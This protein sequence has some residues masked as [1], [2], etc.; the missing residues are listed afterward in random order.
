[1][2]TITDGPSV[3]FEV[4]ERVTYNI[5]HIY[6]ETTKTALVIGASRGIGAAVCARL[7]AAGYSV[8]GT[9]R[10]SGVPEGV[11]AIEA[12]MRD[13]DSLRQAVDTT[14]DA[15]GRLDTLV[16]AAGITRDRLLLRMTAEDIRD[17]LEVNTLGPMLACKAA[18][19]PMLRQRSGS[20]VLLS[21]M[22]VKYGV[23]GQT[24]Y[25]A[26]KGAIEA[27]TRSLAREYAE[28]GI[29]VNA[30]A[31]GATDTDMMAAVPQAE[32]QAMIDGIPMRRLA[33]ADEIASVVVQ[34]AEATY[35]N[36][37]VFPVGGGL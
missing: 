16:V 30:V 28:R 15:L 37:A 29:R 33:T 34:V 27:F 19:R 36:G 12:D 35:V 24:N 25:T 31:P 2:D 22:S 8:W 9:H 4:Q 7:T 3:Q 32:R 13:P 1:M 14:V 10:G 18:L 17:V 23:P 26:S 20:M 6:P 21:S 5:M 11:H